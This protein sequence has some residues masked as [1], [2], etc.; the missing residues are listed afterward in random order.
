MCFGILMLK[1]CLAV[2][3]KRHCRLVVNFSHLF[4]YDEVVTQIF[5]TAL[6]FI[7]EKEK[8]RPI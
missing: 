1:I 4:R 2:K 6:K 8:Q 5:S 3:N 7:P